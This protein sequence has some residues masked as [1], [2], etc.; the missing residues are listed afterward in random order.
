M[1]I[2]LAEMAVALL[3]ATRRSGLQTS[4]R[5]FGPSGSFPAS[6]RISTLPS[7]VFQNHTFP[8]ILANIRPIFPPNPQYR[9]RPSPYART[10]PHPGYGTYPDSC[11]PQFSPTHNIC[12]FIMRFLSS[13]LHILFPVYLLI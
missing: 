12:P 11:Q 5:L 9:R 8:P 1:H 6:S 2:S 10:S 13:R 3:S 4:R 7:A